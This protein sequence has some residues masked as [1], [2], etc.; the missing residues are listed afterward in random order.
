M[1]LLGQFAAQLDAG[2]SVGQ[3]DVDEG[4]VDFGLP[5][6]LT[7][8]VRVRGDTHDLMPQILEDEAELHGHQGLVFNDENA[9]GHERKRFGF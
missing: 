5:H 8:R 1:L 7:R 6:H 4:E 3:V 9:G 2:R